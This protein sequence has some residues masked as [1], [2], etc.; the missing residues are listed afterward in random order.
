[1]IKFK[2]I[3]AAF[4]CIIYLITGCEIVFSQEPVIIHNDYKKLN[5]GKNLEIFEDKDNRFTFQDI[6]SGRFDNLFIK[7]NQDSYIMG[8]TDSAYW[9]RFKIKSLPDIKHNWLIKS[10]VYKTNNVEIYIPTAKGRY[11]NEKSGLEVPID[12]R[13]IKH[14]KIVFSLPNDFDRD[15][16]IYMRFKSDY[17]S[18]NLEIIREDYF[19]KL[20]SYNNTLNSLFYGFLL[21][22]ML[23]NFLLFFSIKD[24]NYLSYANFIFSVIFYQLSSDGYAFQYIWQGYTRFE[25]RSLSFFSF[26]IFYLALTFT[27]SF[28]LTKKFMPKFDIFM[29]FLRY[30]GLIMLLL[31]LLLDY[32]TVLII[33]SYYCTIGLI[34]FII[35]GIVTFL[36][37]YKPARLYL[38]AGSVEFIGLAISFLPLFRLLPI[39][40]ITMYSDLFGFAIFIILLNLGIAEKVNILEEEKAMAQKEAVENLKQADKLKDEFLANTTHELHTPLNGIIG[41]AESLLAGA[42]GRLEEEIKK[43]LSLIAVSGRRLSSLVNDI[44]DFSKITGKELKLQF[45]PLNLKNNLDIV[46]AIS[47]PLLKNKRLELRNDVKDNLLMVEADEN[48]F[49]QIM[50][51]LV[52]NAIKFT[53]EGQ[54]TVEAEEKDGMVELRVIDT[55]IGIP[56]EKQGIIFEKFRQADGSIARKYGGTGLGLSITKQLVELHGGRIWVESE[57]GAGTKFCFTLKKSNELADPEPE[58][59]QYIAQDMLNKEAAI[60]TEYAA[61]TAESPGEEMIL[62]VD[63]EPINIQ[64]IIN[65]LRSQG[66]KVMSALSGKEALDRMKTVKKLPDLVILDVMMP[67]MTGYDVSKKIR[68]EYKCSELPIIMITAKNRIADLMAGLESGAND[69]LMK[70]FDKDEMLARVRN[71]LKLSR[72]VK[73][74]KEF[75]I[76]QNELDIARSIQLSILP[77]RGPE[78]EGLKV[79]TKYIPMAQIGG[80]YYDYYDHLLKKTNIIIADVSGHGLPAALIASMV[81]VAFSIEVRLDSNPQKILEGMNKT[82]FLQGLENFV[83][84]QCVLIDHE[85]MRL[86]MSNA[87][88]LPL[89]IVDNNNNRFRQIKS[90]GKP[91]GVFENI[92]IHKEYIDIHR[93][94]RIILYTDS[95]IE[96]E[97]VEGE[98]FKTDR[99]Y[100]LIME[101]KDKEP[102]EFIE[103]L[104]D[105]LADWTGMDRNF[106]DDFTLVVVDIV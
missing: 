49:Q 2:H 66:Y 100:G 102:L 87:G 88:H 50:F 42:A 106:K 51:N 4:C 72:T 29:I 20:E 64:V 69:Y 84:A 12:K 5:I 80:D 61:D 97:S 18:I 45:R 48:R 13:Q 30:A 39:N 86:E 38:I 78:N 35:P 24:R 34:A 67:E 8:F 53:E 93:G 7:H 31:T 73:I 44:L 95:I 74:Q 22:M 65:I 6:Q 54:V 98:F 60:I 91:L 68:E 96:A 76:L 16:Y 81:K 46:L 94:D 70:P 101:T 75:S 62:V 9:I 37:G 10:Y 103:I 14:R 77:K 11:L 40:F 41:I 1:M 33:N 55:G 82:L 3:I 83:T 57:E 89:V 32:R 105:N 90:K 47:R 52:G 15:R 99:F 104:L 43:N 25:I 63:D 79:C 26:Y 56:K 71:L 59:M 85:S 28:L 58:V 92:D 17:I 19:Y 21:A 23:S 27:Q 36:K